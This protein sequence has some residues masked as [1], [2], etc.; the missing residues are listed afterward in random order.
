MPYQNAKEGTTLTTGQQE[1]TD[2]TAAAKP[3]PDIPA[4][5]L[6]TAPKSS[7]TTNPDEEVPRTSVSSLHDSPG[8]DSGTKAIERNAVA[9][10]SDIDRSR[11]TRGV[12]RDMGT[13]DAEG[14][15]EMDVIRGR[16]PS[17]SKTGTVV[18]NS[19]DRAE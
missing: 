10:T 8:Y 4:E 7:P 19:S 13:D 6:E 17:V 15:F 9:D 18:S 1:A 2:D 3:D 12:D 11:L 5:T 14:G 16:E